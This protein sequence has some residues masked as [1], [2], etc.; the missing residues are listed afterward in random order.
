MPYFETAKKRQKKTPS[1]LPLTPPYQQTQKHQNNQKSPHPIK[2]NLSP[3]YFSKI[4]SP[5]HPIKKILSPPPH[6]SKVS[7]TNTMLKNLSSPPIPFFPHQK[8]QN[9]GV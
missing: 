1:L 6:L 7:P 4:T 9:S 2:S 5:A 3:T 8:K